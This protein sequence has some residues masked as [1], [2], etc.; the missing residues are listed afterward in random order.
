MKAVLL[1]SAE[2]LQD[3]GDRLLLG[4]SR[5]IIDKQNQDWTNSDAYRDPKISLNAQMGTGQLNAFRAYKQ[6]QAGE[7]KP[8]ATVPDLGWDYHT[9]QVNSFQDYV[10]GQALQQGS[11]VAITLVWD[12]LVEL[13]DRNKNGQFDVGENFRD[14]GLNN[15][16]LYLLNAETNKPVSAICTSISDVD[17]V[18]HI[19]C[20]V[21]TTGNYKIRVQ[22][23]QQQ[24]QAIQPYAIAWWTVSHSKSD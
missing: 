14:R 10:I 3:R 18:E 8:S 23:R 5:T 21:A 7:W 9:V 1:N 13:R 24:N 15:L 22:F 20:P 11:Y 4:M 6:F 12:R 19:F 16:N 17:N 2:K